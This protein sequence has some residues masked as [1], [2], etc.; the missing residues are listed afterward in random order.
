[1]ARKTG[2]INIIKFHLNFDLHEFNKF[3][4]VNIDSQNIAG[5]ARLLNDLNIGMDDAVKK[6]QDSEELALFFAKRSGQIYRAMRR[7]LIF[8]YPNTGAATWG[9][10][11]RK[12]DIELAAYVRKS[13]Y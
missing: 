5:L 3:L 4:A 6:K 1:M 13:T 11:K 10:T 12:R 7:I 2:G 8:K 9:E